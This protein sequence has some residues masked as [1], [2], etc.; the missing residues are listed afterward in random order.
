M[1]FNKVYGSKVVL[2]MGLK[3]RRIRW[4]KV[5]VECLGEGRGRRVFFFGFFLVISM[6]IYSYVLGYIYI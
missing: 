3:V 5:V 4:F 2:V 1:L 6:C